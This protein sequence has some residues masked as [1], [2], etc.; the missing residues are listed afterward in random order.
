[1]IT[2][3]CQDYIVW[4]ESSRIYCIAQLSPPFSYILM[5]LSSDGC[6]WLQRIAYAKTKSDAIAKVD[7]SFIEKK[8]KKTEE[9]NWRKARERERERVV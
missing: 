3:L 9:G 8:K 1:M 6:G 7:G 5:L 2:F 4:C